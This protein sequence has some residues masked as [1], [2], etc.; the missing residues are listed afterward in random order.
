MFFVDFVQNSGF[1]RSLFS[2]C[3]NVTVVKN[4]ASSLAQSSVLNGSAPH[5]SGEI[6][7]RCKRLR[8]V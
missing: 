8:F 2:P 1:L 5:R 7:Y 6:I 4:I 3:G